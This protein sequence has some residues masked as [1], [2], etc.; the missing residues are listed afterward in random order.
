M[1]C[2]KCGKEMAEDV[3]FCSSC[4]ENLNSKP[5]PVQQPINAL[6]IPINKLLIVKWVLL[7]LGIIGIIYSMSTIID[8]VE[9]LGKYYDPPIGLVVIVIISYIVFS[10]GVG[11]III[12]KLTTLMKKNDNAL[13]IWPIVIGYIFCVIFIGFVLFVLIFGY[14][15]RFLSSNR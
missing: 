1:F 3:K 9:N 14:T 6:L 10:I 11:L 8:D 7:V 13:H 2:S 12:P 15:F 5:N 4:G